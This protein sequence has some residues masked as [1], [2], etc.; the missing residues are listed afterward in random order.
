MSSVNLKNVRRE[1]R[2]LSTRAHLRRTS[3]RPRLSVFRSVQHITAQVIDDAK[4]HTV[5]SVTTT[6]KALRGE[7]DGKSKTEQAKLIGRAIAQKALDAGVSTVV[8]DRGCYRFH[9]R[10]KALAEAAREAGLKF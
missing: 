7:L 3:N 5:A 9:G 10:I 4:G 8:F 6:A 2:R 1:R